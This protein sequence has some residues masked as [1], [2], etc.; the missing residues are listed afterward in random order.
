MRNEQEDPSEVQRKQSMGL[1]SLL[2]PCFA[3]H[4]PS[5]AN[6]K[7][8]TAAVTGLLEVYAAE[9]KLRGAKNKTKPDRA[10]LI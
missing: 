1:S 7:C 4:F 6:K 2:P 10:L 8:S 3:K 5:L 9:A